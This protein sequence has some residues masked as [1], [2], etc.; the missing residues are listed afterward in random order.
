MNI[1][2]IFKYYYLYE[3]KVNNNS[4]SLH[5]KYYYGMHCTDN[6]DDNYYGSSVIL[7]NYKKKYGN[8][9]LEKSILA[10][11]CNYND[12]AEAEK[13][14]VNSKKVELGDN[15]LNLND[16]GFGSFTFINQTLTDEQKH[17]NASKGGQGNKLKLQNRDNLK[18]FRDKCIAYHKNMSEDKKE[19][20][21]NKVSSSLKS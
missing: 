8:E 20:I 17:I 9:G 14:L 5:N 4:S 16:G 7:K 10:F 13:Q 21:Y 3:I 12:L 6:L 1:T 11:F 18:I 2:K 19:E 15:C